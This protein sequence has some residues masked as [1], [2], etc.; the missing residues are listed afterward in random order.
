[1]KGEFYRNFDSV[2]ISK[3]QNDKLYIDNIQSDIISRNSGKSQ[4]NVFPAIREDIIDFYYK[5]G[6]LFGYSISKGFY[7]HAKY[8]SVIENPSKDYINVTDL[9]NCRIISDFT[10]EYKR[11]KENCS[12]YSGTESTGAS[13]IY[14]R[15]PYTL[16]GSDIVVLD[17]EISF[18]S[19]AKQK[20]ETVMEENSHEGIENMLSSNSRDRNQDRIDVLLYDTKHQEL[21]FV[22]LKHYSNAEIWANVGNKADVCDQIDNYESQI[23]DKYSKILKEY[24]K[25]VNTVNVLFGLNLPIPQKICRDVTLFIFGFDGDQLNGRL[26]KFIQNNPAFTVKHKYYYG[27]IKSNKFDILNLW[28]A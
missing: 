27:N 25:Y 15:F 26:K 3:L 10:K 1:M 9:N 28:N 8:A 6:K 21:K 14:H 17:I 2:A 5:G 19:V 18:K 20:D 24:E 11:I 13:L 4:N 12:L 16:T 7:T 23:T 22:E